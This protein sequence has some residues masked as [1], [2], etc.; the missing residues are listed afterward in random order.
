M[1][2]PWKASLLTRLRYK[3]RQ[4]DWKVS[5]CETSSYWRY[6]GIDV[7][8]KVSGRS[9]NGHQGLTNDVKELYQSKHVHT[10]R[11][12]KTRKA[13][14]TCK[15]RKH[16]E[17]AKQEKRAELLI[18]LLNILFCGFLVAVNVLIAICAIDDLRKL[19]KSPRAPTTSQTL[20]H[21]I[22]INVYE[23]QRVTYHEM[24]IR[25]NCVQAKSCQHSI[26]ISTDT[27]QCRVVMAF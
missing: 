6:R 20:H 22:Y 9:G 10:C 12:C 23:R 27:A 2:L 15:T 8:R 13:C 5:K 7:T 16:A 26:S 4:N 14:R 18:C 21:N 24:F 19:G 17:R 3:E 1:R 25:I 11:S